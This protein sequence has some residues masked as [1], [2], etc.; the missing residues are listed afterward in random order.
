MKKLYISAEFY[1]LIGKAQAHF[2]IAAR[3]IERSKA[4]RS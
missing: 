3:I 4:V 1:R 2:K